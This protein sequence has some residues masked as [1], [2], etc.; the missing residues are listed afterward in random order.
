MIRVLNVATVGLHWG[1]VL[2]SLWSFQEYEMWLCAEDLGLLVGAMDGLGGKVS[3][4]VVF[5]RGWMV[6]GER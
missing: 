6:E 4:L 1:Y 3:E 5:W 2:L